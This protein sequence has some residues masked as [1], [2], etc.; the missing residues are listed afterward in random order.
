MK[1]LAALTIGLTLTLVLL[2]S[3][4]AVD[5]ASIDN[6][7]IDN[8]SIDNASIDTSVTQKEDEILYELDVDTSF[9]DINIDVSFPTD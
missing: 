2:L 7:S 6:A 3:G 9:I 5:N 1:H 4:C 8:A